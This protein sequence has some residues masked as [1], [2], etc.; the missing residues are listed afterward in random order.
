M[1]W[2]NSSGSRRS[3]SA[4]KPATS[5]NTTVTTFLAP[6]EIRASRESRAASTETRART[7]ERSEQME[8][9]STISLWS[10]RPQWEWPTGKISP[11]LYWWKDI[12]T[13]ELGDDQRVG[14]AMMRGNA[15]ATGLECDGWLSLERATEKKGRIFVSG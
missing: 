15:S 14:I 2:R 4:V 3:P 6:A 9:S 7:G 12:L 5:V 13:R 11:G 1:T 8:A 10:D